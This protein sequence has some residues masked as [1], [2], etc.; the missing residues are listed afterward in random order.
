MKRYLVLADGTVYQ[1]QAFGADCA[2]T[3]EL[4][5]TTGMTGYQEAITDDS[6][7]GQLLV[8]T[9][10][11]LGNYGV[12][13]A[14]NEDIVS[15]CAGVICRQV[16][17]VVDS[18][19]S[20]ETLGDF[21]TRQ[22]IPGI[23]GIDTRQLTQKLRTSGTMAARLTDELPEQSE[24]K[25]Q[26]VLPASSELLAKTAQKS[27]YSIPGT[28]HQVV[29]VNFGAKQSI[30][31]ELMKRN[32]NIVVVPSTY[33][34]EQILNFAPEGVVISNGPGDP[35]DFPQALPLI[36]ELQQKTVLLGICLGH[37]LFALANGASTFKMKFGHRGFNH[38]VTEVA[39]GKT[40]FTSQNHGYAVDASSIDRNVLLETYVE[41]NDQ[42]VE[43]LHH[44]TYP[45]LSVQFHPDASPGPHDAVD[46]F[47]DFISMIETQGE[48][49]IA[50][51]K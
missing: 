49:E 14:D 16:A 23:S 46:I 28:G 29:V 15:N 33:S 30:L 34:A 9:N 40:V 35:T 31:R 21:L 17:R 19:R 27:P 20:S 26:L 6:Y 32:C 22:Q 8:F 36:R 5:F 3:G 11:L 10:P 4:V 12:S 50:K 51:E 45:A 41:L 24:L 25:Q 13:V 43:G 47:D 18:W 44:R 42:T 39:T 1:G 37:Q 7:A 48:E 38:P 2:S